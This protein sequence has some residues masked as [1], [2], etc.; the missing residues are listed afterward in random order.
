[1]RS[2]ETLWAEGQVVLARD[3]VVRDLFNHRHSQL[4]LS[5]A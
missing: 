4:A 1:M 5:I 2:V 3:Q